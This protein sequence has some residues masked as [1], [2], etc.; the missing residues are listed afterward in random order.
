PSSPRRRGPGGFNPLN[1]KAPGWAGT[2]LSKRVYVPGY[3]IRG[4]ALRGNDGQIPNCP[5]LP[6]PWSRR[7]SRAAQNSTMDLNP[8]HIIRAQSNGGFALSGIIAMKRGSAMTFLLTLSRCR[9]DL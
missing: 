8:P 2:R 4:Q 7:V 3:S 5:D 1:A 9:R 6:A